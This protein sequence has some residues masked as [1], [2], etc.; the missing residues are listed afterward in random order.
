[1]A[2]IGLLS[3][4]HSF[5]D[6]EIWDY[7]NN[8]DEI[9]H[10]GDFGSVDVVDQLRAKKKIRA[11]F[12][13][14]DG[15]EIRNEFPEII[16]FEL[17]GVRVC[18]K[19]IGGFPGRYTPGLKA[20]LKKYKIKLFISGHSHILKIIPDKELGLL[21]INPGA[22]GREGFHIMRTMVRFELSMGAIKNLEVIELGP[23][24]SQK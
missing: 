19:H 9:W 2:K 20:Q 10:V 7:F 16:F 11:V 21:H 13:N 23:R 5:L 4:T 3:D 8:C 1:M 22:M 15:Q 24:V 14:I 17:E 12:G 6:P 18:M